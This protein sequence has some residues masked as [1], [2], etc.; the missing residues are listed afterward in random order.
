[1]KY[2]ILCVRRNRDSTYQLQLKQW[3]C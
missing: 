1:M 3:L 2:H